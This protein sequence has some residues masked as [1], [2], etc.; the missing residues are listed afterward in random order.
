MRARAA[1]FA[2]LLALLVCLAPGARAADE[3]GRGKTVFDMA[4]NEIFSPLKDGPLHYSS[5]YGMFA[6]GGEVAVNT[7]PITP[8]GL[9]GVGTYV[10]AGPA[11]EFTRDD[12]VVLQSYVRNGGNLLVLMHI[13]PPVARLVQGFG[14]V[15]SNFVVSERENVI[16]GQSQDFFVTRLAWHPITK[17]VERIAVFGTWGLMAEGGG[18]ARVVA[19]T[20]DNAWAD[21]NRN[22]HYDEG[23]PVLSFGI[24][25]TARYGGGKVV[26]V[27]DDA[28]FANEF[29]DRADNR[30]FA[31]NIIG[32][33]NE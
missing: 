14:I 27:A 31:R 15:V 18:G 28:P 20:S 13:A 11:G 16:E 2:G 29:I 33:F 30:K 23:E 25:A 6:E 32:W 19:S 1:L 21:V 26:V 8:S 22:R 10:I 24:A 9:D 5:L 3:E 12:V 17:G 7:G 4:H